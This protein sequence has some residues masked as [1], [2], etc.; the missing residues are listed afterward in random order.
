MME[1]V[2]FL[3]I[4]FVYSL[5]SKRINKLPITPQMIFVIAGMFLATD[6]LSN[7]LINSDTGLILFLAELTLVLVL[8][9]DASR[10]GLGALRKNNLTL[11]LL[12]V[13]LTLT[14]LFGIVI[15][16]LLLTD[17]SI[18]EA[19][20][21]GAVL[22]PT[23]AA[24]GQVVVKNKKLPSLVRETLE[25]E[26][27]L[28]DGLAVPFLLLFLAWSIAK[29]TF[30]PVGF[31]IEAALAQIGFGVIVGL[32]IGLS[33]GWLVLKAKK[34]EWMTQNF[35]RISLIAVALISWL[36]TDQ[37]GGSGFIA[38][39]VGGLATGYVLKDQVKNFISFTEEEGQFLNLFVF[40]LLGFIVL[41]LIQDMTWQILLYALL[42]LTIIRMLP[43]AISLLGSKL[44]KETVLFM[45]W[46]GPRGL[47]SIVLALIAI[48]R[49]LNFP[50]EETFT[51]TVFTTVLL[52]VFLHGI[53]ASPLAS[54][55]AE[56]IAK[57]DGSCLEK[58]N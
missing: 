26:S 37:L 4:V 35:Q 8:F 57:M 53:T 51:L 43:T 18:W 25:I 58:M 19:A 41:P 9:S 33:G 14:I 50:G 27:G 31:F 38:A 2:Y 11:R 32:I 54:V 46:F 39:F 3:V 40:F 36:L 28:N 5:I 24:L 13:S 23:D 7:M 21:I 29:E 52:S 45:G 12:S 16:T 48:E 47:A 56:K 20:I 30:S 42:S 6:F 1:L 15:A 34:Q 44:K 55:Y 49:Q 10:I 17:L 22:A